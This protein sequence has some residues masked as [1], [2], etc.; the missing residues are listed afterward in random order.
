MRRRTSTDHL[1]SSLTDLMTSL[2]V[3]FI[4]LLV[5]K[6]NNQATRTE[7]SMTYVQGQLED[8]KLFSGGEK[9]RRDGDVLVVAIPQELMSFKQATA[10]HGGADLSAQGKEYL[11]ATIP[12]LAAVLCRD[13]VRRR[14]DTILVEGHSDKKGFGLGSEQA[15]KQE[16]LK[17]SQQR[18]MS[19]VAE[20]SSILG[21]NRSCFL[22]L[23][24]ATGR[25]DARPLNV[26]DIYS[27]ENRRVELRIRVKPDA[28][29]AVSSSLSP[30][31]RA[32]TKGAGQ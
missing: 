14:I 25:G 4:L 20:S 13:E 12:K 29:S 16:N 24:S 21:T 28:A 3:I 17:L 32:Q 6:L 2:A 19:V 15:D 30:I 23:L 27:P 10:E 1:S 8:R 11:R 7:R 9:M 31:V 22:D 5:A 18:S 26:K